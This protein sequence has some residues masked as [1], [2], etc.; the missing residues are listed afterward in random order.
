LDLA[1][2]QCVVW[3]PEPLNASDTIEA[4]LAA[5]VEEEPLAAKI[6]KQSTV[7]SHCNYHWTH[8]A[9]KGGDLDINDGVFG[10]YGTRYLGANSWVPS[11]PK[12]P[13]DCE[14]SNCAGKQITIE[15]AA[16]EAT[17]TA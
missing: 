2:I 3:K 10:Q 13:C 1:G 7:F 4:I 5:T 15:Q 14:G 12:R 9:R 17:T 6:W 16:A 8:I 11:D